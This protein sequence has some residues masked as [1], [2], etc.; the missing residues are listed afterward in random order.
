MSSPPPKPKDPNPYD[1]GYEAGQAAERDAKVQKISFQYSAAFKKGYEAGVLAEQNSKNPDSKEA[2]E[3]RRVSRAKEIEKAERIRESKEAKANEA[4]R[5][6]QAVEKANRD[7]IEFQKAL[8]KA[9][10]ASDEEMKTSFEKRM[11]FAQLE[12]LLE[13]QGPRAKI[14]QEGHVEDEGDRYRD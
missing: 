1:E 9:S 5:I 13:V 2:R 7:G 11:S 6:E 12:R 10:G 4:R 8:D 14:D 3:A